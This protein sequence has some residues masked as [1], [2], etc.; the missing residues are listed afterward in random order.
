MQTSIY[1]PH[2]TSMSKNLNLQY[3]GTNVRLIKGLTTL[4]VCKQLIVGNFFRTMY[5][6]IGIFVLF[7]HIYSILLSKFSELKYLNRIVYTYIILYLTRN[8]C[9]Q[10]K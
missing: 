10:I 4:K 3:T 5:I 7:A 9:Y 1:L 2:F 8:N 6:F